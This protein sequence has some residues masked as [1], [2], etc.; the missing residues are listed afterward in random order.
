M[1]THRDIQNGSNLTDFLFL[2]EMLMPKLVMSPLVCGA[3]LRSSVTNG[4]SLEGREEVG[5]V[6]EVV[7]P[8]IG[9]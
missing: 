8:T 5:R 4:R 7:E 9:F 6:C 3:K 2:F 1:Y